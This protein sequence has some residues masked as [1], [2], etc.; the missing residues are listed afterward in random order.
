MKLRKNSF[1][2]Q[3]AGQKLDGGTTLKQKLP[4]KQ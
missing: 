3:L 1:Q 4:I 2:L